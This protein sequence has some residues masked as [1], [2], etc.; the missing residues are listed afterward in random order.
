MPQPG[1][2]QAL[3]PAVPTAPPTPVQA[4]AAQEASAGAVAG[5]EGHTEEKP[6]SKDEVDDEASD[7]S[8]LAEA[9]LVPID[10]LLPP[11]PANPSTV[12]ARTGASA[13]GSGATASLDGIAA[14][15]S[16][17]KLAA[18]PVMGTDRSDTAMAPDGEGLVAKPLEA[19]APIATASF[20]DLVASSSPSAPAPLANNAAPVADTGAASPQAQS[21]PVP[22][23][24]VPMTI[25]LRSLA[26]SNRFEIRLD[27]KDLGRIDVN[28]DIDKDNGTVTAHLVVDRPETLAL[29]QRD[30]GNLQQAL[31]QA[32]F[33]ATDASI[34]LSLRS[35]TGSDGR[36]G[37]ERDR[38][39]GREGA[40]GA[41]GSDLKD[42]RLS[43]D[44]MPLRIL[45]G[46]GGIDI[47]I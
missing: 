15:G 22:L 31:S 41:P 6:V 24:A 14:K 37:A 47:R 35:D 1:K 43:I 30:A 21:A 39:S 45:R 25:G 18:V 36:N 44:A 7:E 34:N 16:A 2:G 11:P 38:G 46:L 40:S 8:A 20:G 26:G 17:A 3:A 13:P 32:G 23:G 29:L 27:P 42:P 19:L 9:T 12:Q 33:E 10:L 5:S 4:L 28:L